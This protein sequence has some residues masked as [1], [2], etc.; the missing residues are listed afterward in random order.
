MGN[1][2]YSRSWTKETTSNGGTHL[3]T[4]ELLSSVYRGPSPSTRD[5]PSHSPYSSNQ[6]SV[7]GRADFRDQSS[8]AHYGGGGGSG[9]HVDHTLRAT[10]KP[11]TRKTRSASGRTDTHI[12]HSSSLGTEPKL[13]LGRGKHN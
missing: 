6:R 5:I 7:F 12:S 1:P 10:P 2:S 11:V 4:T 9:L 3:D 13:N 8:Y